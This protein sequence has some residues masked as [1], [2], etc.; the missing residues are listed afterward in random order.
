M[1]RLV[2]EVNEDS[3]F[4]LSIENVYKGEVDG[5]ELVGC[6]KEQS[7]AIGAAAQF[8]CKKT[9]GQVLWKIN[10]GGNKWIGPGINREKARKW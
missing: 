3:E 4:V 9:D 8:D 7:E 1:E 5:V 10:E 2:L 6:Y